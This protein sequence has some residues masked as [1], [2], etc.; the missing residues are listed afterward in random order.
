MKGGES[1]C[2][3]GSVPRSRQAAVIHLGPPL[4]TARAVYPRASGGQPSN[5]RAGPEGALLT[6]LRVGFT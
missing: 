4:P 3:P 6:L 1:A 2:R 5:A